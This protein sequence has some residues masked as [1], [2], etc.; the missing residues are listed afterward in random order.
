MR[1]R[2]IAPE[3]TADA[4]EQEVQQRWTRDGVFA[5]AQAQRADAPAWVFYEGPPTA[6]GK[7]GIHHVFARTVKDLFCRH[8][9]ML[10]HHVPR[11]AGWDTHGL[12]VEIEVEKQ[13]GIS[14]KQDIERIGVAEFN[15]RCR[16][17]VWTY[18]GD[19]EEVS[20]RMGYWLDYDHPYVTYENEYVE[21]VWWA[22]KTLHTRGLL[23]QGHKILPYCARCGTALSSHELAQGYED[24]E[25][26]SVYVALD[27]QL[28]VGSGELGGTA[29]GLTSLPAAV[30]RRIV[31]WTTT[32]W[33]LVSNVALAVHPELHYVELRKK[34]V[35]DWTIILAEAR[36]GAVLGADYRERWDE[37]GLFKG[38]SLVG[39]SYQ[40]PLDWVEYPDEGKTQ[41][42]VGE[43]FVSADDGSG[44]VHMAPAFGADDYAA[45]QRHGL[46]FVNPVNARGEFP[47][48]MP[49][50]G[51]KFVKTADPLIIEELE[52]RDQLW[53]AQKFVH[54]YPHCWRCGTPLLYYARSSWFV[55]TTAYKDQMMA[56]NAAVNW[57]PPEVGAGRF[58]SWLENNI[59]WAISRDRYWG[60]PLPVWVNDTDPAEMEVIGSYAELA[61]KIGKPLPADFD[62][63]K[64]HVD[65]YTWPAP[66]GTGTMRR[67]PEVIDTWFDSGSMPFAQWGYPHQ[68]GSAEQVARYFPADFIAEGVDQ[69]RGWFYSL[70]AIA[71]G[72]GDALPN[73]GGD[74]TAAQGSAA[75][76]AA[77][78]RAVVVNDLV[79]DA[80][81]QKM[82]KSRGNTVNPRGV[83]EKHGADAVR[84]FLMASSQVWVPRRFDEAVI[85]ET[86]GR[87]LVTL[88]NVYSGIFAQ[89]ANFGWEP[90]AA[91]PRVADRPVLD[92]WVL[93][94]LTA[95][96]AEV[97]A[98]LQRFDATAAAR[99]LMDFV[100]EDVANWYVRLSRA[101]FYEVDGDDNRA[102]FATLHEVL[103]VTSRL[104]AP[105][106][107][108]IADWIHHELTGE[109]VHLAD[110][111]RPGAAD[112]TTLDGATQLAV[113]A[114]V[115]D[116]EL[117]L[118]MEAARTLATLGRAAREVAGVKVRQPLGAMTCVAPRVDPS[119]HSMIAGLVA[120]ELNLKQVTFADSAADWVRLEGKANFPV[121][122]KIVGGAMKATKPIVENLDQAQ[123]RTIEAGGQVT[124]EVPGYGALDLDATRVTITARASTSL[125]VQQGDGL[126]VAL[127]P[128]VTPEL[129]AEG[130]AR[131]VVSR[132]QRLRKDSGLAV[133]D[134]IRLVV[135]AD[136]AVQDALRPH[137]GWIAQETLARECVV[138]DALPSPAWPATAEV[139][140]DGAV[141]RIAL[142]KDS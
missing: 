134:R 27:L 74:A 118:A 90:S 57:N 68:A 51:G 8:R 12:P 35:S 101:R 37:I 126:S 135:A 81:G 25:D 97:D 133:S 105:F 49:V 107:P 42:I 53:K 36:A 43:E 114:A 30:R 33:T 136:A 102:A 110:F 47:A 129:R 18:K 88:R 132:V 2:T 98:A 93:S 91:D 94:R 86:A 19:W 77:P 76:R 66:S 137:A 31:V 121:L 13:L 75:S 104:L 1:F 70:L 92:R 72:L 106:A 5:A 41:V 100:T 69:T 45:G 139:D 16:E 122:G 28:G 20:S 87:F 11:K 32:P 24:V 85:R 124:V 38:A 7:P 73:N 109:S 140:L 4:L 108:F 95:V 6:N 113:S 22:L 48:E 26:P 29:T 59:D 46:A 17:S 67:V 9:A 141:A 71:T 117:E 116:T 99:L 54:A 52:K 56:R 111:R 120:A 50:V 115:V 55:R 79:L 63:H 80:N 21:S 112:A 119:W 40:R 142:T 103:V 23:Y 125:V 131:E 130:M 83:M 96:E 65:Q 39:L 84:L 58:G 128:T 10:G 44:V 3:L 62:P 138:A 61:A 14:G 60:T 127:D 64:P 89:Y 15:R 123:L 34:N 78:Y 82:S